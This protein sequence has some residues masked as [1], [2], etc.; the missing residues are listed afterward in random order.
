MIGA[1]PDYLNNVERDL[2][3]TGSRPRD[4]DATADGSHDPLEKLIRALLIEIGED[5]DRDGL[6]DT[7]ARCARW[8]REFVSY[9][10]GKI[11][12]T[13]E[14]VTSGQLVQVSDIR[15]WSL[16]EHHLLPF[17]CD[18]SIAYV[19][20]H[21]IVGLSKFARIAHDHAHRLQVQERLTVEIADSVTTLSGS[22][23]VAVF[24]NGEHLCM[25]IRGIRTAAKMYTAELR[26][27][28]QADPEMRARLIIGR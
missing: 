12:T 18:V 27:V 1:A 5:P 8:W 13:F 10:P 17:W 25:T 16:C 22:P 9:E 15:V 19:A 14:A 21:R 6:R 23:D 24:A 3:D 28:F 20:H 4:E 2:A 7:P 11:E 26:G